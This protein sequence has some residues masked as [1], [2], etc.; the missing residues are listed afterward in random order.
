MMFDI[1]W[2]IFVMGL[3]PTF[4]HLRIVYLFGWYTEKFHVKKGHITKF[5]SVKKEQF[6]N[7]PFLV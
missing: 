3:A 5:F 4:V 1:V 6:Q 7:I 2:M